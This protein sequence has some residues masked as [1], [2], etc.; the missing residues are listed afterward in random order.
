[1]KGDDYGPILFAEN[2]NQHS[3]SAIK[4]RF[5][6][7]LDIDFTKAT[8]CASI[9][10]PSNVISTNYNQVNIEESVQIHPAFWWGR[11]WS[12]QW[13]LRPDGDEEIQDTRV[14]FSFVNIYASRTRRIFRIFVVLWPVWSITAWLLF[15]FFSGRPVFRR[16]SNGCSWVEFRKHS[17]LVKI[18]HQSQGDSNLV[19]MPFMSNIAWWSS[20]LTR[21]KSRLAIQWMLERVWSQL[22][23]YRPTY[24]SSTSWP[25]AARALMM[26]TRES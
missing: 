24:E 4:K 14:R 19:A 26:S 10:I 15:V 20:E 3:N 6:E 2:Q 25:K 12:P 9:W 7:F 17:R 22:E 21:S 18:Q 1:M 8:F 5:K 23:F 11:Q 16:Q 13:S